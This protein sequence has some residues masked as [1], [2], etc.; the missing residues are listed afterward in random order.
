VPYFIQLSGY[1]AGLRAGLLRIRVPVRDGNFSLTLMSRP[2]LGLTQPPI[3]WV[4]GVISRGGGGVM[5]PRLEADYSPASSTKVKNAWNYIPA[6][7]IRPHGVVLSSKKHRDNFTFTFTC[8]VGNFRKSGQSQ[9]PEF[10]AYFFLSIQWIRSEQCFPTTTSGDLEP[11]Q[12][13]T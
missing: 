9:S 13:E 7:P 12:F 8:V 4:A 1:S 11:Q 10:R 2:A 5:R 3:Q 6:P